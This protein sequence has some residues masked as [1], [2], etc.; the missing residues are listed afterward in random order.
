MSKLRLK[1][2]IPNNSSIVLLPYKGE[3]KTLS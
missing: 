1:A 3:R 2:I